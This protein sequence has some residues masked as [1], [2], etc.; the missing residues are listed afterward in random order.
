MI[1]QL[2]QFFFFL[3][4]HY[5]WPSHVVFVPF[6]FQTFPI[7]MAI[8]GVFQVPK[9]GCP[10]TLGDG[11]VEDLAKVVESLGGPLAFITRLAA[12]VQL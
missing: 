1:N 3:R 5:D 10:S 8:R 7:K 9:L 4:E 12:F 6:I 11:Q 2:W